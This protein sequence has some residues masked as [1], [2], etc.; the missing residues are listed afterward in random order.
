MIGSHERKQDEREK[1]ME[2]SKSSGVGP[3][4]GSTELERRVR[5]PAT[6][7]DTARSRSSSVKVAWVSNNFAEVEKKKEGGGTMASA[8]PT[9]AAVRR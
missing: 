2:V 3:V 1:E 9:T 6:G 5:W 8:A 7:R 4:G